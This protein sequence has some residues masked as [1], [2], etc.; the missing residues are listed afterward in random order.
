MINAPFNFISLISWSLFLVSFRLLN[1]S[2]S[3]AFRLNS[4]YNN[5]IFFI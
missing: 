2:M 3:S 1:V 5:S 4:S